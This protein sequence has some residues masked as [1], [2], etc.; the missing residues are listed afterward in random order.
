MLLPGNHVLLYI[1][2]QHGSVDRASS[3]GRYFVIEWCH[4]IEDTYLYCREYSLAYKVSIQVD[5]KLQFSRSR[6]LPVSKSS[7]VNEPIA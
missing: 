3:W 1:Q 2:A 4:V 5:P 7:Q 6:A